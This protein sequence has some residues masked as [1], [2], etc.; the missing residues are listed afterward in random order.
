M[1]KNNKTS[2][3]SRHH[4]LLSIFLWTSLFTGLFLGL[5]YHII[6]SLRTHSSNNKEEVVIKNHEYT[7]DDYARVEVLLKEYG[8]LMLKYDLSGN[9][10][11]Y[12]NPYGIMEEGLLLEFSSTEEAHKM[13]MLLLRRDMKEYNVKTQ[14]LM[15]IFSTIFDDTMYYTNI[16]DEPIRW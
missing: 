7:S 12:N 5:G 2:I 4:R 6:E 16:P 15:Y 13:A 14:P 1:S 11:A 10:K 8:K 9:L 3:I